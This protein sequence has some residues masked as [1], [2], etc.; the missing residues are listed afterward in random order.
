MVPFCIVQRGNYANSTKVYHSQNVGYSSHICLIICEKLSSSLHQNIWCGDMSHP[1]FAKAT[2]GQAKPPSCPA[3]VLT[4]A[5]RRSWFK[6]WLLVFF[7]MYNLHLFY[8]VQ[9]S[10]DRD[11]SE[12]LT[13]HWCMW[14]R[15]PE[16]ADRY[17]SA[18]S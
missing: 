8:F 3:V 2:D 16:F 6:S 4:E 17:V 12:T 15:R 10:A 14:L 18:F 9:I 11:V 13:L 7:G 1:A 5:D